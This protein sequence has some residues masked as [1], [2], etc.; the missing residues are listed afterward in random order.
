MEF[1]EA[2][3]IVKARLPENRFFHVIAVVETAR[4][5]AVKYGA[6]VKKAEL[7][8]IFHDYSKYDD[9]EEM[10]RIILENDLPKDLI[11][12]D[13]QLWHSFVGAFLVKKDL[14][15][16]DEDILNAIRSHTTGRIGMSLLEQI[17]FVADYI[18]PGRKF[19]NC[20]KCRQI[21]EKSLEEAVLFEYES[22]FEFLESE[23]K[24]IYPPSFE[25]YKAFKKEHFGGVNE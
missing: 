16:K 14:N 18:E 9:I 21:A 19:P 7:A 25:A 15:I 8:A 12:Y 4:E 20:I 6:D 22:V 11:E 17:I 5:L 2:F 23:G 10:R 3:D 1:K 24:R 13:T